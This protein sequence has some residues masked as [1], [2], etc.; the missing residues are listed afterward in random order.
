[1][2]SQEQLEAIRKRAE[3]ATEGKWF[4]DKQTGDL[5]EV[6]VRKY[7]SRV[8]AQEGN[9]LLLENARE[10]IPKLLAEIERLNALINRVEEAVDIE[11]LYENEAIALAKDIHDIIYCGGDSD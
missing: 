9:G 10:D 1:M 5:I 6:G 4:Y 3:K 7:P 8:L 11:E 2:L